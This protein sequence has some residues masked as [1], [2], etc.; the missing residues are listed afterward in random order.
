MSGIKRV[1]IMREKGQE[2]ASKHASKYI[3]QV[4]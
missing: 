3:P 2:I 1:K 4:K